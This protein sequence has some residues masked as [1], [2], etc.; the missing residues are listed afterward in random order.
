MLTFQMYPKFTLVGPT[1]VGSCD[2]FN[3]ILLEGNVG[4]FKLNYEW[5]IE[6]TIGMYDKV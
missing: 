2:A 6:R 1:V 3:I 5:S 4:C